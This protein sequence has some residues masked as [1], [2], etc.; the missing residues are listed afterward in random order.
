MKADDEMKVLKNIDVADDLKTGIC[1]NNLFW[2][3][4][5]GYREMKQERIVPAQSTRP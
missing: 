1:M 2:I 3:H 4:L 5:Y